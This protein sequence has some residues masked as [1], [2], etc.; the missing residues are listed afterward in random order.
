MSSSR[1]VELLAGLKRRVVITVPATGVQQSYQKKIDQFSKK[2]N[3]KGFRK[4]KIPANV[5]EKKFGKGLLHEAASE[6]I[7]TSFQN[8]LS[9]LKLKPAGRPTIDFDINALKHDQDF[10][11]TAEFEIFPEI[12]LKELDGVAIESLSGDVTDEDINNMLVQLR[13]QHSEWHAVERTAKLGDRVEIDFDGEVDGKPLD[14][15]SAKN[16]KLTLGSNSM[17][18][19]FEDGVVGMKK[20]ETKKISVT[21]P[22][23]YHVEELKNKPA[24]FTIHLHA[25][26]EPK[27]PT[28]DDAFAKKLGV[29]DLETLKKRVQEKMQLDMS[30]AAKAMLK[31]AALTELQNLNP[32]EAPVALIDAEIHHL[33]SMTRQQFRQYNPKMSD[34]D[35]NKIPLTREPYEAEARKRVALGLLLAEVIRKHEIK[36]DRNRINQ[37]LAAMASQYGDPQQILP[38]ML[39][40]KGIVSEVE[41]FVLEEQAV[42]VLLGK[43][44][45]SDVKKSYDAIMNAE[46]A[47][48]TVQK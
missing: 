19:G 25:I 42:D 23:E 36:V 28:L 26:E 31:Q 48:Q 13:T 45:V 35:L 46:K 38:I 5:V 44:R 12:E 21:F 41:A 15:G 4:G 27:L 43:A 22:A 20:G 29:D 11:Y 10:N 9:E 32:I 34:A 47:S 8:C 1:K 18:T 39:K 40:N 24:Q 17:I 2:A 3:V 7:D 33:Q 30:E 14:R 37:R 16:H 6:L